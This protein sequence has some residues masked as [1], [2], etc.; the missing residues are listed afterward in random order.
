[1]KEKKK[2]RYPKRV[3]AKFPNTS[4]GMEQAK[5]WKKIYGGHIVVRGKQVLVM[6]AVTGKLVETEPGLFE[7]ADW[8]VKVWRN[9]PGLSIFPPRSKLYKKPFELSYYELAEL[10]KNPAKWE[11]YAIPKYLKDEL[12]ELVAKLL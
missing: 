4:E 3:F 7:W 9:P 11:R 5:L 2:K 8:K 1:M 12:K 10:K 6:R